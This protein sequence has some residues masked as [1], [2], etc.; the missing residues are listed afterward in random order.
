MEK[1]PY[2]KMQKMDDFLLSG[3][4]VHMHNRKMHSLSRFFVV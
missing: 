1:T 3:R 4:F 2:K